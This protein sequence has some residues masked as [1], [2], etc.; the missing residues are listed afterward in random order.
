MRLQYPVLKVNLLKSIDS[1]QD[2]HANYIAFQAYILKNTDSSEAFTELFK[3]FHNAIAENLSKNAKIT[4]LNSID[5]M[6]K[7]FI[8]KSTSDSEDD[9]N[10]FHIESAEHR[11]DSM[12]KALVYA[13]GYAQ[14][15]SG[16]PCSDIDKIVRIVR[17]L[18]SLKGKIPGSNADRDDV[19]KFYYEFNQTIYYSQEKTCQILNAVIKNLKERSRLMDRHFRKLGKPSNGFNA[20]P[21]FF[22]EPIRDQLEIVQGRV[23]R[24][25]ASTDDREKAIGQFV[26]FMDQFQD[27]LN[28][29]VSEFSMQYK[30]SVEAEPRT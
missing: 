22:L 24:L 14:A 30:S 23:L 1:D 21:R 11:I 9:Q 28:E 4:I 16:T 18:N 12:I 10:E 13:E 29:V 5:R 17:E 19:K 27:S 7:E 25:S 26:Q 6:Y 8:A 15:F 3:N 20:S 2:L